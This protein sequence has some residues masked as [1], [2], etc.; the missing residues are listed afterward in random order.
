MALF[1]KSLPNA[2]GQ[3]GETVEINQSSLHHIALEIDIKDYH[4]IL[5]KLH[6]QGIAVKTQIFEWVQW[7]SIFIQDPEKNVIEFVCYD[8]TIKKK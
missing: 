4:I 6:E 1:D 7:R 8:P 3:I 2:F 5:D